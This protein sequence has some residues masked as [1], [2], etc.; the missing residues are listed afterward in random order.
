MKAKFL[1]ATLLVAMTLGSCKRPHQQKE[2]QEETVP[3]TAVTA[4]VDTL[5]DTEPIIVLE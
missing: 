4:P 1:I 3:D 5:T 2:T